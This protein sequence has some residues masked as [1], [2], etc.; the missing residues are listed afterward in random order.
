MN[1]NHKNKNNNKRNLLK[2]NVKDDNRD[3]KFSNN[4][5]D[6]YTWKRQLPKSVKIPARCM[7]DA[8]IWKKMV[9]GRK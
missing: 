5:K 4:H 9:Q 1:R 3:C 8:S 2:K 6:K 7:G